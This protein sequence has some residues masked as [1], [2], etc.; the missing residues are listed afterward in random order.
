MINQS[1]FSSLLYLLHSAFLIPSL[2]R[3]E[4]KLP[5]LLLIFPVLWKKT[6]FPKILIHS[7]DTHIIR[8]FSLGGFD[9]GTSWPRR[10][11]IGF[12]IVA[13]CH[14]A[15]SAQTDEKNKPTP[16]IET[17]ADDSSRVKSPE[18]GPTLPNP[19]ESKTPEKNSI[20]DAKASPDE[21][22]E[23]PSD[24][25]DSQLT[26]QLTIDDETPQFVDEIPLVTKNILLPPEPLAPEPYMP[27][28]KTGSRG[29]KQCRQCY[30]CD[31]SRCGCDYD[32]YFLIDFLFF[33]RNNATSGAVVAETTSGVPEL[34][35]R[36]TNPGTAPGIRLFGG[37]LRK[38]G[39]VWEFGY[40][41]VFGMFG[42]RSVQDPSTL[43]IPGDLGD[44]VTGW[45]DLDAVRSTYTSSLNMCEV[46]LFTSDTTV[47]GGPHSPFPWHR[48]HDPFKHEFQWLGGLRWAG[49]NDI[50][51]LQPN[52]S[53]SG[54]GAYTI[55]TSSQMFGPQFGFRTKR[56]WHKWALEGWAKAT[57][58]GTFLDSD[59][60]PITTASGGAFQYRP[61]TSARDVGVGFVG[62]VNYSLVRRLNNRWSLRAGYNLIWLSG[63]A[64]APN[65]FDFSFTTA[66]GSQLVDG[67]SVFL[68]GANL[69]LEACW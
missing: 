29:N 34:T 25:T 47:K 8:S 43:Q 2:L 67:G 61:Q 17:A 56:R 31:C 19:V 24:R 63:V 11:C 21:A 68:H 33:K 10:F 35:T 28:C 22:Q 45:R 20:L 9:V 18:A 42:E 4:R 23:S 69:G 54:P 65:Q 48:V 32:A 55:T 13:F 16:A 37:R 64:L 57:L 60:A 27:R 39:I 3:N 6:I 40:T 12:C 46:N 7:A 53:T 49:F 52:G 1:D 41:G 44:G 51:S 36:S 14:A 26:D 66:S 30:Q 62:D 15:F 38:N 58:A 59:S 5:K 50:A